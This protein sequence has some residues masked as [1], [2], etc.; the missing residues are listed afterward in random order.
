MRAA[1]EADPTPF[2]PYVPADARIP[3][4]TLRALVLGGVLALVFGAANAYAGLKIGLTVSASIPCAALS[5][6]I[7]RAFR[8]KGNMLEHN[9]VQSIGSSGESLAAG[10]VF[11]VPALFLFGDSPSHLAIFLAC[12]AGGLLG[13]F[14]MIPLRHYL[15]V[16]KHRDLPFPEGKACAELLI[17]GEEGGE[18]ARFLT[19]G[20][21]LSALHRFL[22]DGLKLFRSAF[23]TTAAEL[24]KARLAFEMTPL[25]LGV[26]YLMG[27]RVAA[28]MFGGGIL[29]SLV[30]VPLIHYFGEGLSAPLYPATTPISGLDADGIYKEYVRYIGAGGVVLGGL[31]GLLRA[32]PAMGASLKAS[33]AGF[34]V[35]RTGFG[36]GPDSRL[37]QDLRFHWLGIGTLL[38]AAALFMLLYFFTGTEIAGAQGRLGPAALGTAVGLLACFFF[39]A[40][41]ASMVGL[42]GSSSLPISGMTLGALLPIAATF[43]AQGWT[44]TWGK[45]AAMTITA[46][47]C[48]CISMASDA[49]QDLKITALVGGTPW[50][51]QVAEIAGLLLPAIFAG[52]LLYLLQPQLQSGELSAPQANLM[53]NLISG[54]MQ[55]ELPW[56][57]LLFGA[58][59]GVCVELLGVSALAFSIGMYLPISTSASVIFGGVLAL[60]AGRGRAEDRAAREERGTLFASGLVAGEALVAVALAALVV[61]PYGQGTL[62]DALALRDLAKSPLG[63]WE[64]AIGGAVFLGLFGLFMAILF[65]RRP[66]S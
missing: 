56:A 4:I 61:I 36:L 63:E 9:V 10:V 59:I 55:G 33:L 46:V 57:L 50:K 12:A 39:T 17:A 62:L 6:A 23:E 21:A 30:L 18:K 27:F 51:V 15:V 53:Y 24:H 65:R 26:G 66:K 54:V 31:L 32:L 22:W 37:E 42:V 47:A 3:E 19:I 52:G 40:V 14:L 20:L 1:G 49:S 28:I 41:S 29:G 48:I 34:R 58:V 38:G 43:A 45:V 8:R 5:M 16:R 7:L 11:S 2:R 25:L 44:D 64:Q 60:L 13:L 35:G